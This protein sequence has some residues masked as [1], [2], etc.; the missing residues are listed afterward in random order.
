MKIVS[1]GYAIGTIKSDRLSDS[2][3]QEARKLSTTIT[4]GVTTFEQLYINDK[5]FHT[6]HYRNS[7]GKRRSCYCSYINTN[8]V[9]AY[10]EIQKFV[11]CLSLGTIAFIRPFHGTDSIQVIHVDLFFSNIL[12]CLSSHVSFLKHTH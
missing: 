7:E 12:S 8:G 11:E 10:G 9:E 3:L 2:E 4:R 1:Q 5:I 6:I